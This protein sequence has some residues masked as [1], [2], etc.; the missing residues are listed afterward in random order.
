MQIGHLKPWENGLKDEEAWK[1]SAE[2]KEYS[3]KK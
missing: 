1:S 3:P 2:G